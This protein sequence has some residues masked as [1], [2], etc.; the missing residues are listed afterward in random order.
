[1]LHAPHPCSRRSPP[2]SSP[3][4]PRSTSLQVV[5][6]CGAAATT[7]NPMDGFHG[8]PCTPALRGD[9]AYQIASSGVVAGDVVCVTPRLVVVV[10]TVAARVWPA[11]PNAWTS[12]LASGAGGANSARARGVLSIKQITPLSDLFYDP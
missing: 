11:A 2:T 5:G 3:P 6:V 4:A 10:W 1:M 7:V 8:H 9:C 12:W